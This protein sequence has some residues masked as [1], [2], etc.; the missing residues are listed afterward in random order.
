VVFQ[1]QPAV[2]PDGDAIDDYHF[3]LSPRADLKWPL[4]MTFAKL[5]SRT[6]DA[7]S[8]QYT[9]RAPGELN[10]DTR[11]FWHV[12]AKDSQGVWGPWSETWSFTPRGPA[13]P[14]SVTLQFDR[15]KELGVLRWQKNPLGRKPV[16]YRVYA[17]DEKGF[18]I[19]DEP[20]RVLASGADGDLFPANFLVETPAT[21]LTVV[22]AGLELTGANRAFYRVVAVDESGHR[23][24]PSDYAAAPRP[25]IHSNP[26]TVARAGAEYRYDVLAIHSLGDLRTRTVN[27][28][29][30][31]NYWDVE[32][33]RFRL[34]Q[35]P[36]W[37]S[38]DESTGRMSGKPDRPGRSEV[39]VA[40]TLERD[41]RTLD[42]ARL[43]WGLEAVL[44]TRIETVG[45]AKQTFVIET[46]P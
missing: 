26:V 5:I 30:I 41:E 7:G 2:D 1:W 6:R 22:G 23:S 18:S 9:L 38:V 13:P 42:P 12:R 36:A 34:E 14:L 44:D 45:T 24:G 20:Y 10:P 21:E 17:S 43:Q 31:E 27:G 3:E 25:L 15:E 28:K 39:T 19:S 11:Y 32:K 8:A 29:A 4:S 33:P 37:L 40:V 35:G 16:T 46:A